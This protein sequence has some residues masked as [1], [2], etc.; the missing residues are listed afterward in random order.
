MTNI[1]EIKKIIHTFKEIEFAYL[2]GSV[3]TQT[4]NEK[5]DIDIAVYIKKEFNSFD[6]K[7]K[8]HH[9]LEIKLKKDI[10][11]ISLNSIKNFSLLQD[12]FNEGIILKESNNDER[13]IFELDKE[14]EILDYKEFQRVLDVPS[15][16]ATAWEL[17]IS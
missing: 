10:D 15:F 2:F 8:I 7:L 16:Q 13:V 5:S 3:A 17:K 4:Q 12:I 11:L 6:T 1:D 14:H 9:Q